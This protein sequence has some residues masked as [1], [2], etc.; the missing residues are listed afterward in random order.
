VARPKAGEGSRTKE[1][2]C[3]IIARKA[4][5]PAAAPTRILRQ[6]VDARPRASDPSVA[7]AL[8]RRGLDQLLTPA[9]RVPLE[10][11]YGGDFSA[12]RIHTDA[13]AED[14][15]AKLDAQAFTFG[16]DIY[17]AKGAYHPEDPVGRDIIAHELGHVVQYQQGRIPKPGTGPPAVSHPGDALER[18]ADSMAQASCPR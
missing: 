6:S 5:A 18:S 8:S 2:A 4:A 17:F 12:V 11:K 1:T 10:R 13:A 7:I 16:A 15:A 9:I 3:S 14:A